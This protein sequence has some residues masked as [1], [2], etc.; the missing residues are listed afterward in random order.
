M[1]LNALALS[2][3]LISAPVLSLA[4]PAANAQNF[5]PNA[6]GIHGLCDSSSGYRH[7][8][9]WIG[10]RKA[11]GS[12]RDCRA[13]RDWA[14]REAERNRNHD[15]NS[16]FIGIG[17]DLLTGLILNSQQRQAQPAPS[18]SMKAEMAL[19]KQQQEIELLKMQL[20]AQQAAQYGAPVH[21]QHSVPVR[22]AYTPYAY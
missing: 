10:S 19:M 8:K 16:Q 5:T 6:G 18:T 20:Q 11:G 22:P 12:R 1:K 2:S 13:A 17:G 4:A 9:S 15:R 3:L 14:S 21:V 7:T